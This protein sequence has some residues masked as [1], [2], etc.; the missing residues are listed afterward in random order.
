MMK[1]FGIIK[2]IPKTWKRIVKNEEVDVQERM[3]LACDINIYMVALHQYVKYQLKC[4]RFASR[5][6]LEETC[7]AKHYPKYA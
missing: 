2:A 5:T 1:W 7:L 3:P 4:L 6:H